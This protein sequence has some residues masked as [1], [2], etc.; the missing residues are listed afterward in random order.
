MIKKTLLSLFLTTGFLFTANVCAMDIFEAIE[1]N[2]IELVKK[3]IKKDKSQVNKKIVKTIIKNRCTVTNKNTE[4]T[5]LLLKNGADVDKQKKLRKLLLHISLSKAEPKNLYLAPDKEEK[6]R[7]L[8]LN[9]KTPA[10][11]KPD[12]IEYLLRHKKNVDRNPI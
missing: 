1:A 11:Y 7:T 5:E 12:A 2:N 9:D 10:Y 6:V 4:I 3:I 8:G